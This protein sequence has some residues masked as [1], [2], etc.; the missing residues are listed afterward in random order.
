MN[1][2][3]IVCVK[4]VVRSRTRKDPGLGDTYICENEPCA[5][6]RGAR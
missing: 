1:P 3:M 2:R 5:N 4:A 6:D